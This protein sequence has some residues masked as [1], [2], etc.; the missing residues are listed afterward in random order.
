MTSNIAIGANSFNPGS[1]NTA[2]F[3]LVSNI[4]ANTQFNIYIYYC[5]RPMDKSFF[6]LIHQ[7]ALLHT[8]PTQYYISKISFQ[9]ELQKY[10]NNLDCWFIFYKLVKDDV[11]SKDIFQ[12]HIL[13]YYV[14]LQCKLQCK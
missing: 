3:I 7:G 14:G 10:N 1:P 12:H 4:Y 5:Y 8:Y 6:T 11:V 2:T 13:K 9:T